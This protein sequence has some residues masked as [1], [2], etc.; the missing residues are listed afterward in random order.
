[1]FSKKEPP[2]KPLAVHENLSWASVLKIFSWDQTTSLFGLFGE[3]SLPH[4]DLANS[5]EAL[6][7]PLSMVEVPAAVIPRSRAAN[8]E[9]EWLPD[10]FVSQIWM[11]RAALEPS[12]LAKMGLDENNVQHI[13]LLD[14][15]TLVAVERRGD[16]I[17][18]VDGTAVLGSVFGADGGAVSSLPVARDARGGAVYVGALQLAAVYLKGGNNVGIVGAPWP[19]R[20]VLCRCLH[21]A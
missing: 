5:I 18:L 11:N 2:L 8:G 7:A 1:M 19:P 16:G 9:G 20:W 14:V 17:R 21:H 13:S 6:G 4:P 15:L 3:G 12:R 10:T